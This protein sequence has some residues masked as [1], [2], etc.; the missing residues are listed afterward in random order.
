MSQEP[1]DQIGQPEQE[2]F[3]PDLSQL[4][5]ILA[6]NQAA[7]RESVGITNIVNVSTAMV[8]QNVPFNS[9]DYEAQCR[10]AAGTAEHLKL[11][12]MA[13][14]QTEQLM[15]MTTEFNNIAS[16]LR[17][18]RLPDTRVNIGGQKL[19]GGY[20]IKQYA[21]ELNQGQYNAIIGKL[22]G[23][24]RMDQI[25]KHCTKA[26][27]AHTPALYLNQALDYESQKNYVYTIGQTLPQAIERIHSMLSADDKHK[28]AEL[29]KG[30]LGPEL[31]GKLSRVADSQQTHVFVIFVVLI[32]QILDK[33]RAVTAPITALSIWDDVTTLTAPEYRPTITAQYVEQMKR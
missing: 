9:G 17:N 13:Q 6:E 4:S 5:E 7:L 30:V 20:G 29:L 26:N 23:R 32:D 19:E 31:Y 24:N 21:A 14:G 11:M 3:L 10:A 22:L 1:I 27:M 8:E 12:T 16:S 28:T 25:R 33:Q 18:V 15:Q 2:S